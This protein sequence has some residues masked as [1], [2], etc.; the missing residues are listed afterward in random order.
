MEYVFLISMAMILY[1]YLGYPSLMT[2]LALFKNPWQRGNTLP[3]VSLLIAAYNEAS[4]IAEK[5]EN[6]L[7]L[8]Y[9]KEKLEIIIASDGSIDGTNE[10]VQKYVE[11]GVILNML[12]PRG[13]KTSALNRTFHQTHGSIVV[14]SDAN[15]MYA[16]D[17][18]RKL[19]RHF[20]NPSIGAVTGDVRLINNTAGF[21]DSEGLYYKYERHLQLMESRVNS[22]I[23]VDGAM[24]AIRRELFQTP[25][26]NIILDD[27]VISMSVAC[28][29]FRVIYDAEAIATEDATPN[30][31]QEFRRKV[32]IISGGFQ[33]LKQREGLL[34]WNQF[35]LWFEYVSHKLLRWLVPFFLI[36]LFISNLLIFFKPLLLYKASLSA[37]IIFYI[38]AILG[39]KW[40]KVS[41]NIIF[42]VPFY[43]CM[44]NAAAFVGFFKGMLNKQQVTWRKADRKPYK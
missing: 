2:L 37:Q 30:I 39:W 34:R 5:I 40:R 28:Q 4:V 25:S 36:G 35:T 11:K 41:N 29:G 27:F 19:V 24:Y 10:I 6:S 17:A 32:R 38:L 43:F 20:A 1:V 21:G 22:I 23:G 26:N 15:T 42:A 3:S 8:D 7:Q 13:G 9:P 18:I 44:L 12:Q 33:A 31:K 16:P 14:F